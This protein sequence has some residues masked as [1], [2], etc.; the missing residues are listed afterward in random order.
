[1]TYYAIT[2]QHYHGFH[3]LSDK[4]G[5]CQRT[6]RNAHAHACDAGYSTANELADK[7]Q[8]PNSK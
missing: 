3:T 1:M 8:I 2:L 7:N 5:E 4:N 6:R